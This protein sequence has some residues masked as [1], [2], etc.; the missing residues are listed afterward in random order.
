MGL[1]RFLS[2]LI[3][4]SYIHHKPHTK[5]QA[6]INIAQ[7]RSTLLLGVWG[8]SFADLMLSQRSVCITHNKLNGVSRNHMLKGIMIFWKPTL[9]LLQVKCMPWPSWNHEDET[10]QLI[11]WYDYILLAL[12]LV[13]LEDLHLIQMMRN[14]SDLLNAWLGLV[15][16]VHSCTQYKHIIMKLVDTKK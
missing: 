1:L 2:I 10:I 7:V 8:Q 5:L 4:S 16:T 13:I 3:N 9:V 15:G 6:I 11:Y 12:L 14:A